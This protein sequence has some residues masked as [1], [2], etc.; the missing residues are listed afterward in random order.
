MK[1]YHY[2]YCSYD[3]D[4][5]LY[6]GVRKSKKNPEEDLYLGSFKDMSF[7][8]VGKWILG[9]FFN[10]KDAMS[11]EIYLHEL[12]NV[13]TNNLFI[14]RANQKTGGFDT[15]GRPSST[16]GV[17]RTDEVKQKLRIAH[18]GRKLS[19]VRKQAIR[20][21]M[22]P[23][24]KKI[25]SSQH[26]GKVISNEQRLKLSLAGMGKNVSCIYL[27]QH[28]DGRKETAYMEEL[29][30]RLPEENLTQSSLSKVAAGKISHHRGWTCLACQLRE[31]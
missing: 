21:S 15:T 13:K 10:R 16:R 18:R 7:R 31:F 20:R 25:I 8:P 19:E 30:K 11:Y 2:V 6:I 24:R 28:K 3:L 4:Y 12:W 23:E 27:W 9:C 29:M 22:T 1:E 5:N 26:K 17:P 14:N